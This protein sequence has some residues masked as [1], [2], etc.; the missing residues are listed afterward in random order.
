M[1]PTLNAHLYQHVASVR[2]K[3]FELLDEVSEV[4]QTAFESGYGRLASDQLS[5]AAVGMQSVAN[6]LGSVE[7]LIASDD[8][9]FQRPGA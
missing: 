4:R 6:E 9:R 7:A 3:L 8:G 5:E 2:S 1:T